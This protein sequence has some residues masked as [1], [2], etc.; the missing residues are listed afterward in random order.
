MPLHI[1][2]AVGVISCSSLIGFYQ[3]R[4]LS[5]R[6]TL[7]DESLFMLQ[8]MR[9]Y[10]SHERVTTTQLIQNLT[11]LNSLATLEFLHDCNQHLAAGEVFPVAWEHALTA[12]EQRDPLLEEDRKVLLMIGG[13][14]GTSSASIQQDEL[15]VVEQL[16]QQ[17]RTHAE[18]QC[19]EKGKL[20]R[21]LGVLFGVGIAILIF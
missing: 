11:H 17:R 8:K 6:V 12:G 2:L 7:L 20:Y 3:S 21:S 18:T 14:L 15:G 9:A 19:R 5:H 10:L 16:L 4:R 1:L 13:I